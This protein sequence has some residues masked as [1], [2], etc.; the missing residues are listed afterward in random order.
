VNPELLFVGTEFAL[1]AS[2]DDG[3]HWA[4]LKG[5]MPPAQIRDIAVQR[6]ETD[7]VLATFAKEPRFGGSRFGGSRKRRG[8]AR[9]R[10]PFADRGSF[11]NREPRTA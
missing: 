6:R 11:A 7:L 1:F 8:C 2:V 10:G 9:P 5:G 3:R 4:A